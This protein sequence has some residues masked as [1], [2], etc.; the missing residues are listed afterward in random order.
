MINLYERTDGGGDYGAA[1]FSGVGTGVPS[2]GNSGL[3][4]TN[5]LQQQNQNQSSVPQVSSIF[6]T[7]ADWARLLTLF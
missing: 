3:D 7:G 5:I 2:A 4:F 1:A 6:R